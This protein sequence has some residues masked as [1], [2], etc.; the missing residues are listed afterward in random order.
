MEV[1][2]VCPFGMAEGFY[3]A[4]QQE[5][6]GLDLFWIWFCVIEVGQRP[7]HGGTANGQATY[8]GPIFEFEI[9]CWN[10]QCLPDHFEPSL[11]DPLAILAFRIGRV[12]QMA[13]AMLGP[14]ICVIVCISAKKFG[15]P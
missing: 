4:S 5:V 7:D 9:L 12:Q 11:P 10:A 6:E 2:R 8:S 15:I 1:L 13:K 14:S 3:V